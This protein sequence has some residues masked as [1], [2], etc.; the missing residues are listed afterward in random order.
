MRGS[1][2]KLRYPG[3]SR[4]RGNEALL[5]AGGDAR[6]RLRFAPTKERNM[7]GSGGN[8]SS[9]RTLLLALLVAVVGGLIVAY[10]THLLGWGDSSSSDKS[11]RAAPPT[12][13]ITGGGH[14][15]QEP[16][17]TS[18]PAERPTVQYLTALEPIAAS[19]DINPDETV[20]VDGTTYPHSVQYSCFAFCNDPVGTV[21]YNLGKRYDRLTATVGGDDQADASSGAG[22]FA[23][24][25]DGSLAKQ[26][27]LHA[28]DAPVNIDLPVDGVLRLRLEAGS[29]TTPD[30]P[31]QAGANAA[32][33]VSH[34][35]PDLVWGTPKLYAP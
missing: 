27:E 4:Q 11:P 23:I 1:N 8:D 24:Y 20:P 30:S 2:A 26:V 31:I 35:L 14:P 22:Y 33:G 9:V 17:Q 32:G 6:R 15:S 25:L 10:L 18:A 28:G 3:Y 29:S 13:V 19:S 21:E 7:A 16:H 34:S 12:A 5:L